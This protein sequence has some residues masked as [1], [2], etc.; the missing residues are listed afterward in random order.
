MEKKIIFL[1]NSYRQEF[2]DQ[3]QQL[4]PDYQ[5]KTELQEAD[6]PFVEISIGWKKTN[7]LKLLTYAPLKWV[8]VFSAGVDYLPLEEFQKKNI[9]LSNGSGIH[10]T[11]ISEH[12]LG[13]LLTYYRGLNTAVLNQAKK[14]WAPEEIFYDQLAE[15]NMLVIGTGHIGEQLAKSSHSLGVKVFGIN[16][17]GHSVPGF[18]ET[19]SMKNL[20]KIIGEMDVVV[21][22]LPGTDATY[23]IFNS[24][25]FRNMK[26]SAVFVNVGRGDTVHT[27]ELVTALENKE[28]AFA[29]LDV[30]ESEPLP[31]DSPLWQLD[32]VLLTPHVSGMTRH[33]QKKFMAITLPNLTHFVKDG[34]LVKNKI[35]FRKGY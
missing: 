29:A 24:D 19:Y 3:I 16:S 17:T 35:D 12:I 4:A 15:K 8:Q 21:G 6:L 11:A 7:E 33:F 20:T 31:A 30:F 32:N 23:H 25:L 2:L 9:L 10:S 5:I 22:I 27:K 14:R 13:M 28:I 26:K 1:Q 18:A 34:S